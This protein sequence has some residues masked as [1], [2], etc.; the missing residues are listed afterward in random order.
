MKW[1]N[2]FI[3]SLVLFSCSWEGIPKKNSLIVFTIDDADKTIYTN[4]LPV[5]NDYNFPATYF[6]NTSFIDDNDHLSW[7]QCDSL[8]NYYNW[9]TGGHTLHHIQ[10][11]NLDYETAYN[12]VSEDWQNL[13]NHGLSHESFALPSGHGTPQS[14]E[15]ITQFYDNIRNSLDTELHCPI[16]RKMLGYFVY[17]PDF[18]PQIVIN[19]IIYGIN[20]H[21]DLIILGFHSFYEEDGDY[22]SNCTPDEL[23]TI[24]E[25]IYEN[26]FEVVTLK[27]A[28]NRLVE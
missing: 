24:L 13:V 6:I 26:D 15:I 22:I 23:R 21:E 4:G 20:N 16:D 7:V 2:L 12:E 14:Y 1:I 10:L 25:F 27:E 8:E 18:N 11:P 5:F 17:S 28:M 3:L 9:E 19:R